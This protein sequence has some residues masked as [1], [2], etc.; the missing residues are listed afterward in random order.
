MIS[1]L[2]TGDIAI[3]GDAALNI[4]ENVKAKFESYDIRVCNFEGPL[5]KMEDYEKSVKAGPHILQSPGSIDVTEKLGFNLYGLA[6]NHIMDYGKPCLNHTEESILS[7]GAEYIGVGQ[8]EEDACRPYILEKD[9]MKI[10]ILCAAENSFGVLN[11]HEEYGHA[12]LFSKVLKE[13]IIELRKT[14]D[15]LV[16]L[17]HAGL[18]NVN[19]PMPEW[20]DIYRY[21]IDLGV[22]VI[23]GS[24]PHV[25]QGW[26]KYKN[27]LIFYSLGNFLWQ[28]RK[29][30]FSDI[31]TI[32]VGIIFDS[33]K[34]SYEV[35]DV[36]VQDDCLILD[37]DD[38]TLVNLQ[39]Y[40]ELLKDENRAKLCSIVDRFCLDQYVNSFSIY[41]SVAC[42]YLRPKTF[43]Q[44]LRSVY[45]SVFLKCNIDDSYVFHNCAVETNNFVCQRAIG[46]KKQR[47]V[48]VQFKR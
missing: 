46:A 5:G 9:G 44:Y 34:I 11:E 38:A 15:K 29:S 6:N 31:K 19:V 25:L 17:A 37:E 8:T 35:I 32:A 24:H 4:S 30:R 22:D 27:G 2:F 41:L 23:I 47:E 7:R 20:V 33:D 43:K 12:W 1:M 39:E 36:A 40:C 13:R 48:G 28:R 18:E 14:C 21:F 16:L 3:Q 26:E 42:G 45:K 10:A